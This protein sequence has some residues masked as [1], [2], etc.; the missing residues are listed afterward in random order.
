MSADIN[1]F[2]RRLIRRNR[3]L[4]GEYTRLRRQYAYDLNGEKAFVAFEIIPTLLSLNET[5][6][7]GFVPEGEKGCGIY[8][9]GT[10]GGMKGLVE[11]YFPETKN[12]RIPYQRYFVKRPM[13]ESLF[14]MGSAGTV[15]QTEMSDF[16]Y[17]VCVDG[18]R[19][20]EKSIRKLKRN[21]VKSGSFFRVSLKA[22]RMGRP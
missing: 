4:F 19:F 14:L 13:I 1:Q 7:P 11:D 10:S 5:G 21:P 15:A 17:W 8:G 18:L 22:S 16:D 12:R 3:L 9:M 2:D 20:K 6:L